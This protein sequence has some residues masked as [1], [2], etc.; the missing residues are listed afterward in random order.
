MDLVEHI[1]NNMGKGSSSK[2]LDI[3]IFSTGVDLENMLKPVGAEGF[4]ECV[5]FEYYGPGSD[6][7]KLAGT[8][9]GKDL[10]IIVPD[11]GIPTKYCLDIAQEAKKA[12]ALVVATVREDA[13][14]DFYKEVDSVIEISA[15]NFYF[16]PDAHED[17]AKVEHTSAEDAP[18]V[19]PNE[20]GFCFGLM[21]KH[22]IDCIVG[23]GLLK[24]DFDDLKGGLN[25]KAIVAMGH[26]VFDEASANASCDATNGAPVK[27]CVQLAIEDA[28]RHIS[29]GDIELLRSS[30]N[31]VVHV[32]VNPNFAMAKFNQINAE[33]NDMMGVKVPIN[34]SIATDPNCPLRTVSITIFGVMPKEDEP[35][36]VAAANAVFDSSVDAS[37]LASFNGSM[38][39]ASSSEV[40][41]KGITSIGAAAS[42]DA[43]K[44]TN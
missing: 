17:D 16:A 20:Q 31:L 26:G 10:V 39:G 2:D 18:Y 21:L 27:N 29:F 6:V 4:P 11:K 15:N 23:P 24:L 36:A 13:Q 7:T 30:E 22:M 40:D 41:D 9:A 33:I 44:S 25:A 5:S 1:V 35:S 42:A 28:Q 12:G 34:Y 19:E 3:A 8:M 37:A 38:Q 32:L 14:G 43:I